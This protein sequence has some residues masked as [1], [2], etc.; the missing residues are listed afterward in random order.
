MKKAREEEK[1]RQKE[2]EEQQKEME[3]MQ[4]AMEAAQAAAEAAIAEAE[5]KLAAAG[6]GVAPAPAPPS[7]PGAAPA[8][9]DFMWARSMSHD[10]PLPEDGFE[11]PLVKHEDMD[12]MTQDWM[13][14]R[15]PESRLCAICAENPG[16]PWCRG[17]CRK[18][19][20]PQVT[21]PDS[22]TVVDVIREAVG[23]DPDPAAST[24]PEQSQPQSQLP[25]PWDPPPHQ[26]PGET[27]DPPVE[28]HT[29]SPDD[30]PPGFDNP[31]D[32][33]QSN[34]KKLS[35][36]SVGTIVALFALLTC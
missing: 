17:K 30:T 20:H 12:T 19:R 15:T 16:N 6:I 25:T 9:Q 34:A 26:V 7:S 21:I 11:G 23:A 5:E 36:A 1:R 33:K 4:A 24:P 13:Q 2:K 31:G 35:I 22:R 32:I 28:T 8:P 27:N 10:Q 14:E 3:A 29:Q 18:K